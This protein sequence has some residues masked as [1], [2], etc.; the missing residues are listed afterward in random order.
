MTPQL[1][2]A[3]ELACYFQN[4]ACELEEIIELFCL[5]AAAAQSVQPKETK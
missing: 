2:K 5:D 3:V 1:A 4:L